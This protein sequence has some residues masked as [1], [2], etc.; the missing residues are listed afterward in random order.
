V[1]GFSKHR[2]TTGWRKYS[3]AFRGVRSRIL[4]IQSQDPSAQLD[5]NASSGVE[6]VLPL[7]PGL[8]D[9]RLFYLECYP[10]HARGTGEG[11]DEPEA[12]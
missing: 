5:K 10:T 8:A 1:C 9:L 6:W 3:G 2:A 11:G 4:T 12:F 7:E